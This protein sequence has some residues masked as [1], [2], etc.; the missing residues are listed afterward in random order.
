M[1]NAVRMWTYNPVLTDKKT[2][3]RKHK[4]G[5]R[6][7][8]LGY[9]ISTCLQVIIQIDYESLFIHFTDCLVSSISSTSC[10]FFMS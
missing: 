5:A 10:D 9:L 3:L 1:K 2:S 7:R 8:M 6:D 4:M